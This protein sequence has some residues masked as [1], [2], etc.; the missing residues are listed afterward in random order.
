MPTFERDEL[1]N[2]EGTRGIKGT[3]SVPCAGNVPV[4][5]TATSGLFY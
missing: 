4:A 2:S 5:G 1:S 3:Q